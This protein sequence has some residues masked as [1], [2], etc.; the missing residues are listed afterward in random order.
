MQAPWKLQHSGNIWHF[1]FVS[2]WK[3]INWIFLLFALLFGCLDFRFRHL[4]VFFCATKISIKK[5]NVLK[6]N[7]FY[8]ISLPTAFQKIN[9]KFKKCAH[10][11][12]ETKR[13]TVSNLWKFN[14]SA[15]LLHS[16]W[17]KN[18]I[19]VAI[20]VEANWFSFKHFFLS[21]LKYL[22]NCIA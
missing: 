6:L 3:S 11:K 5:S 22:K 2:F 9:E 12:W 14:S 17:G 18:W 16:L 21:R 15:F 7:E 4:W 1:L 20:F 13:L 19:F 8:I 10:K